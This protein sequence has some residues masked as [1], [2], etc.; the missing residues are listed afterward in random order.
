MKK[1]VKHG[2]WL[3]AD[4]AALPIVGVLSAV[5][6]DKSEVVKVTEDIARRATKISNKL[7]PEE[8][9]NDTLPE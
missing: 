2:I 7:K 3:A 6:G 4:V 8:K 9:T 1:V 5:T